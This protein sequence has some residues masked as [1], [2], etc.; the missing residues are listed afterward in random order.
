MGV[1]DLEDEA[2]VG[3]IGEEDGDDPRDNVGDLELKDIF[4]VEDREG[5]SIISAEADEGGEDADD[6]V[7]NNLGVFGVF[8]LEET[9]EFRESHWGSSSELD[10]DFAERLVSRVM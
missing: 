1:F 8:G 9:A 6:E 2:A 3:K 4:G 10:W 5:E 7:A